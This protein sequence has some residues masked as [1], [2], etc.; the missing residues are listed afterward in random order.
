MQASFR[1]GDEASAKRYPLPVSTSPIWRLSD[2]LVTASIP[3]PPCPRHHILVPSVALPG[4]NP[5]FQCALQLDD[6]LWLL[7]AVPDTRSFNGDTGKSGDDL[8]FLTASTGSGAISTHIDCFHTEGDVAES[9]LLIRLALAEPPERFLV[10]LSIRPLEID[11]ESPE[12]ARIVLTPP[13]AISQMRGPKRI[14]ARICSPTALAMSLQ[15]AQ[16]AIPWQALVDACFDGRFYGSWPLAI[17][18]AGAHGRIG[19]V[20]A[21]TSWKPVLCVLR[22]GSPVV[23][24]IRFGHGDL[25]GAPLAST[26]GHL[27]TVYG[28]DGNEILVNDPAAPDVASVPRRYDLRAFTRAWLRWRGAAYLL[29]PP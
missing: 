17:R 14:R 29:A 28:I 22:T 15:A 7:Q 4:L 12:R 24:S 23:A 18:C 27:V 11:P 26:N 21:V 3:V 25:P 5:S 2:G 10:T 19:A 13:P 6:A 16:P 9:R 20:E 8:P 1:Y